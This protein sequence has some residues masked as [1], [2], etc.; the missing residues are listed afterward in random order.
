[1]TKIAKLAPFALLFALFSF[2]S[3]R[4]QEFVPREL[5]W[6]TTQ[7][8]ETKRVVDRPQSS[9]HTSLIAK[10]YPDGALNTEE[11]KQRE[12][13]KKRSWSAY[14]EVRSP[15]SQSSRYI[16]LLN[17]KSSRAGPRYPD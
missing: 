17:S 4:A 15:E 8:R 7:Q 13:S 6:L 2:T 10:N 12:E 1:M 3:A 14:K 9:I 11:L 5:E 16:V